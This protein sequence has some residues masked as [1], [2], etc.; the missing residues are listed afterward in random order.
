M[1]TSPTGPSESASVMIGDSGRHVDDEPVEMD[2]AK[3]VYEHPFATMRHQDVDG[4]RRSL[5][6]GGSRTRADTERLL[7]A[8]QALLTQRAAIV[9]ARPARAVVA[10]EPVGAQ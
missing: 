6:I 4:M 2:G 3:T 9:D 5:A 10:C 8:C 1:P 7:D